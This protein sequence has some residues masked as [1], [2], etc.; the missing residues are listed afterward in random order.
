MNWPNNLWCIYKANKANFRALVSLFPCPLSGEQRTHI[1]SGFVL[2][3]NPGSS[4]LPSVSMNLRT[5]E[6]VYIGRTKMDEPKVSVNVLKA[7]QWN[8]FGHLWNWNRLICTDGSKIRRDILLYQCNGDTNWQTHTT[9]ITHKPAWPPRYSG[10]RTFVDAFLLVQ[11]WFILDQLGPKLVLPNWGCHHGNDHYPCGW[12]VQFVVVDKRSKESRA[13]GWTKHTKICLLR[14]A[15]TTV[16]F[17][18]VSSLPGSWIQFSCTHNVLGTFPSY[19]W[20]EIFSVGNLLYQYGCSGI[21][22]RSSLFHPRQVQEANY[23]LAAIRY[24]SIESLCVS[25]QMQRNSWQM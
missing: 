20:L 19:W 3:N 4:R 2:L 16:Y 22:A 15:Q 17:T 18:K 21:N 1:L 25:V 13:I 8:S 6:H 11:G 5:Q 24:E 7:G 12:R 10:T 14:K 23:T 9:Y